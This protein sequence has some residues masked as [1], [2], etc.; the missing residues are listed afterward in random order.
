MQNEI[1][2]ELDFNDKYYY[3]MNFHNIKLKYL[4]VFTSLKI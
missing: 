4:T 1:K 3:G 2:I